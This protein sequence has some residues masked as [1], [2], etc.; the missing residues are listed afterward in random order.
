M[1]EM[2]LLTRKLH[3]AANYSL[4]QKVTHWA[5]LALCVLQFPTASAIQRTHVVNPFGIKPSQL[6]L[7]FHKVHAWSGWTI[8]L[9]AIVLLGLHMF[10]G[11]PEFSSAMST[12]QRWL[13]HATHIGLYCGIFA[14]AVTGTGSMYFSRAFAP[15]HIALTKIGIGLV[16][17]HVAAALWHQFMLRDGLLMRMIMPN[18]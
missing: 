14:L 6:D 11:V 8:L 15:F 17:L 16:A 2:K 1:F 13:A 12:W 7:L 10:R 18:R 4:M 9:L 3:A 5:I